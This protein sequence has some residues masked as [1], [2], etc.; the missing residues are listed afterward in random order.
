VRI[1][2]LASL[3]VAGCASVPEGSP[4]NQRADALNR[5]GL[6]HLRS[7]DAERARAAFEQSLRIAQSIEHEA[8]IAR[9]WYNLSVA[10]Q[11]LGRSADAESAL[12]AVLQHDLAYPR[13]QLVEIALRKAVLATARDDVGTATRALERAHI[14]CASDC[15]SAGAIVNLQARLALEHR[16]AAEALAHL[17]RARARNERNPVE[18]ANTA[19][20]RAAALIAL[21]RPDEARLAA[22][23]ALALDKQHGAGET[24][25][26][27][28]MLLARTASGPAERRSFLLRAG[29]VARALDDRQALQ[30][31][32]T[33]LEQD[34][35]APTAIPPGAP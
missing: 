5:T 27:D 10:Y 2:L 30:R 28:L 29:D 11:R 32:T 9:G 8:G 16:R 19:R 14:D 4:A 12:D 6:A 17:D 24:I 20:L 35:P 23:E 22:E 3:A 21:D 1:L 31:V 18:R 13:D 25:Y 26:Q 7:G 33:L 34:A 15:R